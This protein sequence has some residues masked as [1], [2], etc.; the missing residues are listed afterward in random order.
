MGA[1]V[2]LAAGVATAV[3]GWW[4]AGK[5]FVPGTLGGLTPA[6]IRLASIAAGV[7]LVTL[8]L[9]GWLF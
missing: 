2:L 7:V 4:Y 3:G 1:T 5:K 8:G 9:G 6:A